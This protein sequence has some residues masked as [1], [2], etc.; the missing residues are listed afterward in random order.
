MFMSDPYF[1]D[2]Q[3]GNLQTNDGRNELK[4]QKTKWTAMGRCVGGGGGGGGANIGP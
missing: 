4:N 3:A 2:K 1:S